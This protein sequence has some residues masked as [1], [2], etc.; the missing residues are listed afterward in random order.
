MRTAMRG[1]FIPAEEFKFLL[2]DLLT[3]ATKRK[4]DC[5][6]IG[7]KTAAK[8][9]GAIVAIL[10]IEE[11]AANLS[12]PGDLILAEK[13]KTNDEKPVEDSAKPDTDAGVL[14]EIAPDK[15][16]NPV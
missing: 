16:G 13:E 1:L 8:L 2:H 11:A 12:I 10:A 4:N 14:P 5:K 6:I 7:N 3:E 9:D 15:D